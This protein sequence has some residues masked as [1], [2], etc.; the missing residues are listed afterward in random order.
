M[1]G[2]TSY[3]TQPGDE[4]R[5]RPEELAERDPVRLAPG[6]YRVAFQNEWLRLLDIRHEPGSLSPMHSHPA[7]LGFILD[8]GHVRFITP[9]GRSE[10]VDLPEWWAGF[11]G[12]ET[13]AVENIGD[14]PIHALN[15]E[16]KRMPGEADV[17]PLLTGVAD[18]LD[19]EPDIYRVLVENELLRA[20]LA[21]A[22][23]GQEIPMHGHPTMLVYDVTGG[24]SLFRYPDGSEDLVQTRAGEV[25]WMTGLRH[26]VKDLTDGPHVLLM[27]EFKRL[28]RAPLATG[29]TR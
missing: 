20:M 15:L 11:V 4:A 1:P 19:V 25:R 22:V 23:P 26:A 6:D 12:P 18:A 7:Y 17:V 28:G 10:E 8:A 9:D 13:H 21:R 2:D 24:K 5:R 27:V 16:L 3:G 14:A 29:P